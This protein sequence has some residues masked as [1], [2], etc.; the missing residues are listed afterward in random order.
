MA[1]TANLCEG[2]T[3]FA[4]QTTTHFALSA[5]IALLAGHLESMPETNPQ[6][7]RV[8][9]LPWITDLKNG[10]LP[11]AFPPTSPPSKSSRFVSYEEWEADCVYR[12]T[13]P[14]FL[15]DG[16]WCGYWSYDGA[17]D[18]DLPSVQFADAIEGTVFS[19]RRV[20]R[21][22]R[23]REGDVYLVRG[24][25]PDSADDF[26]LEGQ[27]TRDGCFTLGPPED[28]WGWRGRMTPFGMFGFWGSTDGSRIA[29]ICWLW[30]KSWSDAAREEKREKEE[31][32]MGYDG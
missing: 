27:Y 28:F 7:P 11:L 16:P 32:E 19:V 1:V 22:S 2:G 12:M 5:C 20:R 26:R 10:L 24:S 21:S 23:N 29:G 13:D 17:P 14:D 6:I 15:E 8:Q 9:D 3:D 31:R 25:Y 4:N 18:H 30:K